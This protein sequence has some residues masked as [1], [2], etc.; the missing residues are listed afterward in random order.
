MPNPRVQEG[1]ELRLGPSD[2]E[3]V[4]ERGLSDYVQKKI[5]SYDFRY[6]YLNAK[7]WDE[8]LLR[9]F[10]TLLEEKLEEAGEHRLKR[11]NEGWGENLELF[12]KEK[13][14]NAVRPGYFDKISFVRWKQDWVFPLSQDFEYRMLAVIQDWL[15]DKYF[16][17]ATDIYEFGCGT[18]H[19]LLRARDVNAD[20]RLFGLDWAESSQGLLEQIRLSGKDK[21]IHGHRFNFFEPD[22][23]FKLAPG[24]SVYTVAA[25][26]QVGERFEAFIQYLLSMKP[27][28]VVHIEPIE[29]LLDS[30]HL[31]D[32]ISIQYFRKRK[33]LRGL[34]PYLRDLEAQRQIKIERAERTWIGSFFIEGYSVIVWRP[35]V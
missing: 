16:R 10:K 2:F 15:F 13:A 31:L 18:G 32:F 6:R 3:G 33:Y 34:L 5:S 27:A 22:L 8:C 20:A 26:E 19:N 4:F 14:L 29:E 25:L 35:I 7:E 21:N 24:A 12:Q 1:P 28:T 23:N 30:N 11:W 17:A 9:S